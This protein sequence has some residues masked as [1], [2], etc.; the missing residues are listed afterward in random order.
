MGFSILENLAFVKGFVIASKSRSE[1][2]HR[3]TYRL[4]RTATGLPFPICPFVF[5]CLHNYYPI[6]YVFSQKVPD[7]QSTSLVKSCEVNKIEAIHLQTLWKV[8]SPLNP[9]TTE[10][11]WWTPSRNSQGN[12]WSHICEVG[13]RSFC[14]NTRKP[15][16]SCMSLL[17]SGNRRVPAAKKTS[18]YYR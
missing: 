1:N 17:P 5:V 10:V 7:L 4:V 6:T 9:R 15:N 14:H 13:D 16:S 8:I 3:S 2:F 18:Y 12:Q 11:S